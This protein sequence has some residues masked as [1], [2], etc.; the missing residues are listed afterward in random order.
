MGNPGLF[1]FPRDR[2]NCNT[3]IRR[4]SIKMINSTDD[5]SVR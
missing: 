4:N 3:A 2:A 5:S 1:H